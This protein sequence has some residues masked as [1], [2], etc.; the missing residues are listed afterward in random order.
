MF[1]RSLI[2]RIDGS[3][4]DLGLIAETIFFYEKTQLLLDRSFLLGLAKIL[5]LSDFE[6]LLDSNIVE[7]SY[8]TG[9]LGVV[10]A[11]SPQSH[12]FVE[13]FVGGEKKK[14]ISAAEEIDLFL[15]RE[16]KEFSD[17]KALIRLLNRNVRV[18]KSPSDIIPTLARE[19]AGD[20]KYLDTAVRTILSYL[21]P[22]YS[23]PADLRFELFET[24]EGYAVATNLDYAKVNEIYHRHVSPQ[25]SSI[26]SAYLLSFIQEAR[27]E[28]YFAA[29]Y[30]AELVTTS[31]LGELVRLKHFDF[32]R[33]RATSA[34]QIDLF[35]EIAVGEVPSIREVI[36]SGERSFGEFLKFVKDGDK[37]RSWLHGQSL[38][39]NLLREYQ[40][41]I[42]AETWASK[43]PTK[44]VRFAVATG[45]GML[46]ELFA[47]TGVS[48][49]IGM[50]AG[51]AD[52]FALDKIIKGWRPNQ[53]IENRYQSFV[54]P[55]S[56]DG[57]Q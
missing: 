2:R 21:V 52:T 55:K 33:R 25:H 11:G 37:F 48:T 53:F 54:A 49:A 22:A 39:T 7:L 13:F 29:E 35:K 45:I 1:D 30:L 4:V 40:K 16:L 31:M 32:L 17:A 38:D 14:K 23:I 47:P 6:Q 34:S 26:T 12:A 43:L 41:A 56:M 18:N 50:A 10:S 9:N 46:G 24:G 15:T 44:G 8:R 28:S 19:D 20:Q 57:P 51:A 27:A 42:I 3:D 5:K 36:N